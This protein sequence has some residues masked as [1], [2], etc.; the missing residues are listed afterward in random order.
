MP[1]PQ[2]FATK[3]HTKLRLPDKGR[4]NKELVVC[5]NWD[6]LKPLPAKPEVYRII[7]R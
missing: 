2:T 5:T 3:Y 6:D 1:L 7:N 4:K